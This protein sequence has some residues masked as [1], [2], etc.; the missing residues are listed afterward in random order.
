MLYLGLSLNNRNNKFCEKEILPDR[1][2][3]VRRRKRILSK[4][5]EGLF[6]IRP[7]WE[8]DVLARPIGSCV[9]TTPGKP[10]SETQLISTLWKCPCEK[11]MWHRSKLSSKLSKSTDAFCSEPKWK[12]ANKSAGSPLRKLTWLKSNEIIKH[13]YINYSVSERAFKVR[14]RFLILRPKLGSS[15]MGD[16]QR[17]N[18]W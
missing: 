15:A 18:N 13:H 17:C 3:K 8:G 5:Q 9:L 12:Y 4:V 2:V 7:G 1:G 6:I 11:M 16:M 10:M 14:E